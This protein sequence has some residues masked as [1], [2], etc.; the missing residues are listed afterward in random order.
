MNNFHQPSKICSKSYNWLIFKLIFLYLI[1]F[2]TDFS[3]LIPR[4]IKEYSAWWLKIFYLYVTIMSR[5][6]FR[7]NPH[8]IVCVNVKK[9]L[10]RNRHHIWSL[11]DSNEIRTH[12]HLVHKRTLNHLAKL[13]NSLLHIFCSNLQYL[14]KI[15][16]YV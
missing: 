13:V 6:N 1:D 14:N 9:L 15:P 3:R 7:V 5:T 10:A 4:H 8:P 11:S 12:I 2:G 16:N